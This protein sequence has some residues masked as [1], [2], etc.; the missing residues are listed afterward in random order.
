MFRQHAYP[1]TRS[2]RYAIRP[3]S[4]STS[5]SSGVRVSSA[6]SALTVTPCPDQPHSPMGESAALV[7]APTPFRLASSTPPC[8][9]SRCVFAGQHTLPHVRGQIVLVGVLH[10]QPVHVEFGIGWFRWLPA[11]ATVC[12]ATRRNPVLCSAPWPCRSFLGTRCAAGTPASSLGRCISAHIGGANSRLYRICRSFRFSSGHGVTVCE[13]TPV[14]Q[15]LL[16]VLW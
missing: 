9:G 15:A 16:P 14:P 8:F 1:L 2:F 12:S 6:T 10:N 13:K 4:S 7:P 5:T 3:G 11:T